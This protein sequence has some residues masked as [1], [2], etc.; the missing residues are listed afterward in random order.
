MSKTVRALTD[1]SVN[2][3][4]FTRPGHV[5][6]W[7]QRRFY[8][9]QVIRRRCRFNG[10]CRFETCSYYFELMN[11]DGTLMRNEDLM[12]F[13]KWEMPLISVTDIISYRKN[14]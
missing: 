5:S 11:D 10:T 13:K 8:L 3:N 2:A 7:S 12:A 9:E 14:I 4:D 6:H 1:K